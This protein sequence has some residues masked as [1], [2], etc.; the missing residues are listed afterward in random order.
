MIVELGS[1]GYFI[2]LVGF[3]VFTILIGLLLKN[4]SDDT[5]RK[6]LIVISFVGF[7]IHF[8]KLL[9]PKYYDDLPLSLRKV[10]QKIFAQ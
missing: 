9:M 10:L 3:L 1:T 4:K 6:M 8:L 7:A 5:K 2:G